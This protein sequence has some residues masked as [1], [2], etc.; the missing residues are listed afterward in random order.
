VSFMGRRMTTD[1]YAR[2]HPAFTRTYVSAGK[3]Y[4][5]PRSLRM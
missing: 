5:T 1:A 2:P 3:T 4:P